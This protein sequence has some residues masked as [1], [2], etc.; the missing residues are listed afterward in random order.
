[1]VVISYVAQG[2]GACTRLAAVL[3][4]L[5][6]CPPYC[7]ILPF[8]TQQGEQTGR[9]SEQRSPSLSSVMISSQS[10]HSKGYVLSDP[11]PNY[12]KDEKA[13][14]PPEESP[15]LSSVT[16][17]SQSLHSRKFRRLRAFSTQQV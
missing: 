7:E 16:I 14:C 15:S 4:H 6:P 13:A 9:P 17:S 2:V 12:K 8:P 3:L 11:S 10:V 5:Q 1:M